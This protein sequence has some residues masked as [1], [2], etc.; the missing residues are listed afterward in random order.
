MMSYQ[1]HVSTLQIE[2]RETEMWL[3]IIIFRFNVN[4][5]LVC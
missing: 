5:F 3:I 1:F 2:P 4:T